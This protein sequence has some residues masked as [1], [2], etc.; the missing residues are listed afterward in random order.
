MSVWDGEG[1]VG[2]EGH[3]PAC[4]NI[5]QQQQQ[6]TRLEAGVTLR[7][8]ERKRNKKAELKESE[9]HKETK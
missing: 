4:L 8:V 2:G 7:L 1:R 3:F 6:F 5:P 9:G